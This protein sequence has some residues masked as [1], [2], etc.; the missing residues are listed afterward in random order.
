[1]VLADEAKAVD[2]SSVLARCLVS[3]V[4]LRWR[5]KNTAD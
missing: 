4:R 1:M 5:S 3:P 2:A